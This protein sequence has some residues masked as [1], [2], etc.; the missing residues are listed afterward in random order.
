MPADL[1]PA[2]GPR[3]DSQTQ[4]AYHELE[5]RITQLELKP[6]EVVSEK[7][8]AS[9]LLIGRTPVREALRELAREGLVII[10]PQ[11]GIIISEIDISKQLRLV[12]L[13]RCLMGFVAQESTR[14][15]SDPQR[16]EIKKE[17]AAMRAAGD[18][19][20]ISAAVGRV[21]ALVRLLMTSARNEFALAAFQLTCGL[22]RRFLHAHLGG[23]KDLKT[24]LDC[25]AALAQSVAAK[26]EQEAVAAVEAL[27]DFK[28]DLAKRA[29]ENG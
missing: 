5:R 23:A 16:D 18:T 20:D 26:N 19:I 6:G 2:D 4:R 25:A 7:M 29:L 9:S 15:A 1:T 28:A 13:H 14:R 8:L 17:A 10:L 27:H 12:E 3:S 22:D 24:L 11:R 21:C